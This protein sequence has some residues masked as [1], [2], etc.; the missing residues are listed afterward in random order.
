MSAEFKTGGETFVLDGYEVTLP[1]H[2]RGSTPDG[3]SVT[4]KELADAFLRA[5]LLEQQLLD[6]DDFLAD[7][8]YHDDEHYDELTGEVAEIVSFL[9]L[10][11]PIAEARI[12]GGEQAGEDVGW[13]HL[14]ELN[15]GLLGG[16]ASELRLRAPD[17][18]LAIQKRSIVKMD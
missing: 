2:V 12:V 10:Y 3:I 17:V 7:H 15:A 16:L 14:V 4:D 9:D 18:G 6:P 13:Q 8:F 1:S 5:V 11:A